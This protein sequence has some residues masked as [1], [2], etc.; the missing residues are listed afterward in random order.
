MVFKPVI[1]HPFPEAFLSQ[2]PIEII[3][4]GKAADVPLLTGLTTEEG[5]IKTASL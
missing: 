4:S 5:D 3:T 2:D 1:E